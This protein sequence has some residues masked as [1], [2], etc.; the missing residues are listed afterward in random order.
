MGSPEFAVPSLRGLAQKYRVAGVVSQPD[1]A[2]GRGQGVKR[3]PV[4]A[5]ALALGLPLIQPEKL[6]RP[7]AMQQ[8]RQWAPD[9]VVVAAF[10]RILRPEVLALPPHGCVN[11]HAS[12]LPRWRG[13]APIQAAILAGDAQAGVTVMKM[14]AGVDTG[15]MI[16]QRAIPIEPDDTGGSLSEKLAR[17]GAELLVETLPDYLSGR[18]PLQPQ[19]ES[20]ATRAPILKKEDGR[21]D[22]SRPAAELARR[23][24]AFQPWPG[25][26]FEWGGST[27]KVLR[28]HPAAGQAPAGAQRVHEGSPAVG[29]G[30]GLLVLDEV[31]PAG[32][33]TMPGKA[34]L[35]GGRAWG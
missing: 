24:R 15:A 34:F 31:Q 10:G 27:L 7:E 16:A 33:K 4:K 12:L 25:A 2:A 23:V 35:A 29:T 22:F 19:D 26:F 18:L 20:L 11:V 5:L 32:R 6:N 3:P 28:A 13:A 21:L 8:L 30:D 1:R 17:L 9:L 14:D